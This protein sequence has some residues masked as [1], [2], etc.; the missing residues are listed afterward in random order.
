M[1]AA[2]VLG[3]PYHDAPS[4]CQALIPSS[5]EPRLNPTP[6]ALDLGVCV[7]PCLRCTGPLF[8]ADGAQHAVHTLEVPQQVSG[9]EQYTYRGA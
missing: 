8:T 5:F 7:V 2:G 6:Y 3:L 4:G 9:S 1:E